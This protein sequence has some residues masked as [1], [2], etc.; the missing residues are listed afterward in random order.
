MRSCRPEIKEAEVDLT[1]EIFA[2]LRDELFLVTMTFGDTIKRTYEQLQRPGN[3]EFDAR[4]WNL[5]KPILA[6]G[7]ATGDSDIVQ[8]L[9][10]FANSAYDRKTESFNETA[11]ENV[12]LRAL[13]EIVTRQESYAFDSLHNRI[14]TFIKE[15]GLNVG[16]L[17]KA[18]LGKIL[19]DLDVSDRRTVGP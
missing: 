18:R 16:S 13:G 10:G 5:F 11:V 2:E 8:S 12:V 17:T 4:E 9:V 14:L 7:S 3:A 19:H 15:Q 1:N 6:I